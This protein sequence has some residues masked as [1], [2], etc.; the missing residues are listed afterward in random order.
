MKYEE[1]FSKLVKI[2]E[3]LESP[4][5]TLDESLKLYEESVEYTRICLEKLKEADGK[6]VVIKSEIDG[7]VEKP[8]AVSEE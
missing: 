3:D 2:K 1:A 5:I 7:L 4:T 8:L 6:I